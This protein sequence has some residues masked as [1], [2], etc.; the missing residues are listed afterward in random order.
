[1]TSAPSVWTR[2]ALAVVLLCLGGAFAVENTHTT[3]LTVLDTTLDIPLYW[4]VFVAVSVGFFPGFIMGWLNR[5]PKPPKI[6]HT[7]TLPE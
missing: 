2:R 7:E 3:P 6:N 4:V 5:T 1:M